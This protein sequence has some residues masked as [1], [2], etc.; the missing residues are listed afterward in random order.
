MKTIQLGGHEF[1]SHLGDLSD[2]F[3]SRPASAVLGAA[4]HHDAAFFDGADKNFNGTSLD[5]EVARV[6]AI[7]RMHTQT[8]GWAGIGYHILVAPSGRLH[9]VGDL[10]SVRAHVAHRN[11]ELVGICGMGDF[12]ARP[13]MLGTQ[14]G[15]ANALKA[16]ETAIGPLLPYRGHRDW[17]RPEHLAQWAT[18]CPGDMYKSWLGNLAAINEA[19]AR[20]AIYAAL[21]PNL[22]K[23]DLKALHAQIHWLT[24]AS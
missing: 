13:P 8:N 22:M 11:T 2:G 3:Y 24:G 14:L 6:K 18:A 7:H 1:V 4:I 17:V 9:L 12:T 10:L 5:E 23:G 19:Q 16:C 20:R 15:Y 21:E